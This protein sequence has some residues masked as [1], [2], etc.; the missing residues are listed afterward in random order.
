[1]LFKKIKIQIK[2]YPVIYNCAISILWFYKQ[3]IR[4]QYI[5]IFLENSNC[6]YRQIINYIKCLNSAKSGIPAS[7]GK[8]ILLTIE[9]INYCNLKC[10]ICETGAGKLGRKKRRMSFEEFK[11]ILEQFDDNLKQMYF[12]FMGEPFLNKDAYKMVRY[13]T[14][15]GI[16]VSTCANAS[17]IDPQKL[18]D[19][20][21]DE[22]NFQIAGMTQKIHE[23]YRINSD[24]GKIFNSIEE[25]IR[26]RDLPESNNKKMKIIVGF[27]LMKQNEH[28][29]ENF[30]YYCKKNKVDGYNIIGTTVRTS[31]QAKQYMPSDPK[32]HRFIIEEAMNNDR[33]V[34]IARPNN[35]CGWI[36]STATIMVN[37]DVVPCCYDPTGKYVVGNVFKENF[38]QIWN[39]EKYQRIRRL[40]STSSNNYSLCNLCLGENVPQLR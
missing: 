38:Y 40:V 6:S 11:Y 7:K 3:Y 4:H 15:H 10:P 25:T 19:C 18:V 17:F 36:Y 5:R 29:V 14:D 16:W 39:N 30:L 2:K 32:Y 1:M 13:A 22:V 34:P 8:P 21:I 9:P 12:Y 20:G 24:L 28:Q 37:G 31:A 35:Y 23:I 27:I 33:L 26:I